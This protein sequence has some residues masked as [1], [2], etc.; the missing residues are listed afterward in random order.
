MND[1][2]GELENVRNT[3]DACFETDVIIR[4]QLGLV[5]VDFWAEWC[6]PCRMLAPLLEK[7]AGEFPER[8]TLV[9]ANTEENPGAAQAFG[10][11]GIPA[12]YAVLDGTIID[13]FQGA[14]PET[15]LRPWID[16]CLS[17]ESLFQARQLI[18]THPAAA[19]EQLREIIANTSADQA[20]VAL[21]ELLHEQNRIEECRTLID[22]LERRGFLERECE[23]IQSEL[24]LKS[25]VASDLQG[26]RS[27]AE[28]HPEEFG[29]QFEL[30]EALAAGASFEEA[31]NICLNLVRDDRANFG[32]RARLLMLD[33]FRVL[34]DDADLT[35]EYRRKL[36]MLLY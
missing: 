1:S 33:I 27:R 32:E 26:L 35:R 14:L 3:T 8:L 6:A 28:G 34:G 19:E 4:S 11:T 9:K 20:K 22:E 30:A 2:S 16:R 15:S 24:E 29:L 25:H 5:I 17:Q 12:V 7:L 36:S 31:M 13:S 21:L 10:V 23:K 18:G